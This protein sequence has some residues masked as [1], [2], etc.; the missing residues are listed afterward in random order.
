MTTVVETAA[1]V[2]VPSLQ[3]AGF[4]ALAG[5]LQPASSA[6]DISLAHEAVHTAVDDIAIFAAIG[7]FDI[8]DADATAQ[9]HH[10]P[11]PLAGSGLI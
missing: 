4:D 6:S 9:M 3:G 8:M 1:A 5:L 2:T 11:L 7:A 10:A